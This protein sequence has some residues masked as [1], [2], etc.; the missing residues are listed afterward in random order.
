[1]IKYLKALL[2][3]VNLDIIIILAVT[4]LSQLIFIG[5]KENSH[6]Y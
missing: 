1:M 6:A 4:K 5:T 3:L 2:N